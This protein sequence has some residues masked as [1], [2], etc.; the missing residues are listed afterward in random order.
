MA[1]YAIL[2]ENNIVVQVIVG[3]DESDTSHNWEE[4]YGNFFG[5][6]CKRTSYNTIAGIHINDGIPFRKNYAG[7]GYVYDYDRDAFIPPK[8]YK[9]WILNEE[10]C[11]WYP[12]IEPPTEKPTDGYIYMWNEDTLSWDL[13]EPPTQ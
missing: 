8:P 7:K 1:H 9:S 13:I 12:P 4:Y 2:D 10:N 11:C 5:K 3:K 6:V